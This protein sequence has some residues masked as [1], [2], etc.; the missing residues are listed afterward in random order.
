MARIALFDPC[1]LGALRPGDA[2]HAR[3]VLEALGDEVVLIDGRCCGQPAFNSGFRAEARVAGREMLRALQPFERAVITSGSCTSMVQH[4]LPGLFEGRKGEGARIIGGRVVEFSRHVAEH[5][6]LGSLGLRLEG[7]V[8]YHD[9]CHYR[10][11]LRQ[12]ATAIALMQRVEGLE[13]RRLAYEAECCG[14]GGTF[15]SKLPEVSRE[16]LSA[17]LNDVAATGSRVLLSTDFSCLAHIEA[18]G[19]AMGQPFETWTLAELLAR[20][21]G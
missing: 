16:M 13:V 1:Y 19:R 11:E 4:Y 14:F 12:T 5:P 17:K 20:A 3:R 15:S 7:T 9:S 21:L 10:R 2:G 8:A 18:G 6:R